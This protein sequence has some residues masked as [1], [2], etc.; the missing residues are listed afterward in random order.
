MVQLPVSTTWGQKAG[1]LWLCSG[2]KGLG[3]GVEETD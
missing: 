3:S 1:K 2:N